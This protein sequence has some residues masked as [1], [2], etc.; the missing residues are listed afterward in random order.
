MPRYYELLT[1]LKFDKDEHPRAA[2]IKLAKY[3]ISEFH[4]ETAAGKAAE[5]FTKVFSEGG[6]PDDIPTFWD[7]DIPKQSASTVITLTGLAASNSESKRLIK[8][9][10]VKLNG[11]VL[12]DP[13][14]HF[15]EGTVILQVGK[16]K[17][18]KIEKPPR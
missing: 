9:G 3:V 16:R 15:P 4:S 18:I 12:T 1:G 14:S 5:N 11:K 13:N 7:K 17:F 8:Q 10:S 6:T 2:K